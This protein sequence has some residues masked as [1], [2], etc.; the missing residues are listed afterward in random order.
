MILLHA[1]GP[2]YRILPGVAMTRKDGEGFSD[3]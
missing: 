1:T 3:E 2:Q